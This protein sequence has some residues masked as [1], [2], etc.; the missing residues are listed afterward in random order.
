M[1]ARS[2]T[3]RPMAALAK[4]VTFNSR[5]GPNHPKPLTPPFPKSARTAR[6]FRSGFA[7]AFDLG[8]P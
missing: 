6:G 1:N 7:L 8:G 3:L 4:E 5:Q 2:L